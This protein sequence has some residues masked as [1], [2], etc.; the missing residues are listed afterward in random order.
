MYQLAMPL[1]IAPGGRLGIEPCV[2]LQPAKPCSRLR[3][4]SKQ[5]KAVS[6]TDSLR[7]TGARVTGARVA[8]LSLLTT[9]NRA[10]SH[11]D[12]EQ[13]LATDHVDRVTVYRVLDWLTSEGL[14]HKIADDQRVFRFSVVG[15]RDAP[16]AHFKCRT[17]GDVFCLPTGAPPKLKL[18]AGFK[19][20]VVELSIK[21]TCARCAA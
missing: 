10:L 6:P 12:V 9:A 7:A 13:A 15:D 17:C 21:G 2:R 11:R 14:A 16:H 5:D 3:R 4:M 20:E 8:I 1:V 19:S 18:P